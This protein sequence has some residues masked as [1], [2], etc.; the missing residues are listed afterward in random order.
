MA[1]RPL[2]IVEELQPPQRRRYEIAESSSSFSMELALK[3][4]FFEG[5]LYQSEAAVIAVCCKGWE[6][7]WK[8]CRNRFP[9]YSII[10]VR[11]I[12]H[13]TGS[14]S[15]LPA[16]V[17]DPELLRSY[18]FIRV[19]FNKIN[20]LRVAGKR[21]KKLRAE[22]EANLPIFE[23]FKYAEVSVWEYGSQRQQCGLSLEMG[24]SRKHVKSGELGV[25]SWYCRL[26]P[27]FTIMTGISSW[28]EYD[29]LPLWP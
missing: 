28:E 19:I 5:F 7:L 23:D 16:W 8:N 4:V 12:F 27:D 18:E 1:K 2:V 6:E 11:P 29:N 14:P 3:L 9:M 20:A 10:Q 26:N 17:K 22:A 15:Q 24:K 25:S 21:T 13:R